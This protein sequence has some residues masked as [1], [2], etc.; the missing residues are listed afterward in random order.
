MVKN[1]KMSKTS[2]AV[3][4]LALL[5]VFSLVMGMTGAWFTDKADNSSSGVELT[6]GTVVLD[7]DT[8]DF[9]DVTRVS[10]TAG[11]VA[12]DL[13]PGDTVSY[14]L[15]VDGASGCEDFWFAVVIN[16]EGAAADMES[17]LNDLTTADVKSWT[18]SA[19]A[20]SG[21]LL[22]TGATYGNAYQGQTLTLTYTVVAVQKANVADAAAALPL[23]KAAVAA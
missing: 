4:V 15:T 13:M 22:L 23:L 14:A 1:K 18:G 10:N 12:G 19:V 20:V 2:I 21:S 5:L 6:F 7:V 11:A 17:G 3:I 16:T 8:D 9:G